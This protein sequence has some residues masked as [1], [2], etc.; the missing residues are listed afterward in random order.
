[1]SKQPPSDPTF[2]NAPGRSVGTST[3]PLDWYGLPRDE[4]ERK[5]LQT[6]QRRMQRRMDSNTT[7][8][9]PHLLT[10]TRTA[11][12]G[13]RPLS[14]VFWESPDI[15]VAVGAPDSNPAIPTTTRVSNPTVGKPHTL[16]AHA[17]N[18]GLAPA[19]GI[20]VEFLVFNPSIAFDG[21]RPLFR[22]VTRVDLAGRTTPA[23]CHRLVKCPTA[24]VPTSDNNG[25]ECIIVRVSGVGDTLQPAHR[26][27]PAFDRHVAQRNLQVSLFGDNQSALLG[28]LSGTLPK[29][30]RLKYVVA[31][32]EAQQ[33]VDLVAPGLLVDPRATPR[34]VQDIKEA[35]KPAP[36][37]ATVVRIEGVGPGGDTVGGYSIVMTAQ[38]L[39]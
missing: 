30:G 32:A 28:S 21:Q 27:E 37:R 20:T 6:I 36:G 35:P 38:P 16:Y 10:R 31:G 5:Q 22:A 24:W 19:I 34:V 9:R 23:E 8:F 4:L 3:D 1:M 15:W 25:H 13:A 26:F 14:G 39:G 29:G 12:R 11:D 17:W 33:T 18:L 2:D 7:V